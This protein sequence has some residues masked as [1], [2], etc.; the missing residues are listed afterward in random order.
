MPSEEHAH[1]YMYEVADVLNFLCGQQGPV[2]LPW[3]LLA[4]DN[5]RLLRQKGA[6]WFCF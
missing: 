3:Y 5:G 2:F 6:T 4:R 1:K